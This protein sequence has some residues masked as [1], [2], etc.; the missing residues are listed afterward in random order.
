MSFTLSAD[1]ITVAVLEMILFGLAVWALGCDD[2]LT[3]SR[4]RQWIRVLRRPRS[5][6]VHSA[7]TAEAPSAQAVAEVYVEATPNVTRGELTMG[8]ITGSYAILDSA[9]SLQDKQAGLRIVQHLQILDPWVGLAG[10]FNILR[11]ANE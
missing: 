9:S 5:M 4:C 6:P 7:V 3:L 1:I 2:K 11:K 10:V 8:L